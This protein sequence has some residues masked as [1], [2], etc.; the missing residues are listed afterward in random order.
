MIRNLTGKGNFT[1]NKISNILNK[2]LQ[3]LQYRA[4]FK[5][6]STEKLFLFEVQK[7]TV[8]RKFLYIFFQR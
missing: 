2:E 8:F 1:N 4:I 7:I 5:V 3:E 6:L